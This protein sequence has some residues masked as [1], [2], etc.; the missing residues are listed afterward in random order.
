MMNETGGEL[1]GVR[2][3]ELVR[4]PE[5]SR[6]AG[7]LPVDVSDRQVRKVDQ[8]RLVLPGDVPLSS[9]QGRTVSSIKV[10]VEV[11]PAQVPASRP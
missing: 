9:C 5:L 4:G 10:M 1:Y 6:L 8:Q 3:T 2:R 7:D 11:I